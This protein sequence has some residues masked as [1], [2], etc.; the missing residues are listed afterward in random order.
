MKKLAFKVGFCLLLAIAGFATFSPNSEAQNN[1]IERLLDLPAPPPPNAIIERKPK[2]YY[3]LAEMPADDAPIEDL[4]GFWTTYGDHTDDLEYK[5]TPSEKT[6]DRIIEE[7]QQ[8]PEDLVNRLGIFPA[9]SKYSEIIRNI[10]ESETSKTKF[11]ISWRNSIKAWLTYNSK[12]YSNDLLEL[13]QN[14][15]DTGE[16]LTNHDDLVALGKIDWEKARPIVDRLMNDQ[17]QPISQTAARWVAYQHA[18]DVGNTSDADRYRKELQ[19]IVENKNEKPGNRDLAMD[20]IVKVGDFSGR[21]DWYFSLL[22]DETLLDLKVNGD[23]YTGI[24]TILLN[25]TPG[26]YTAKMIELTKSKN[27]TVRSIAAKN[28]EDSI[29]SENPEVAKALLPWLEDPNWANDVSGIRKKLIEYLESEVVIESVPG[30]LAVLNEKSKQKLGD[31]EDEDRVDAIVKHPAANTA[32]TKLNKADVG[33]NDIEYYPFRSSAISALGTQKDTRAIS[34]LRTLLP[35]VDS[36]ERP[37]VVRALL[38]CNGFSISEQV[39]A[40]ELTAKDLDKNAGFQTKTALIKGIPSANTLIQKPRIAIGNFSAQDQDSDRPYNPNQIPAILGA[41]LVEEREAS[42]ELV[43]AMISRISALER[44][45]PKIATIM[46]NFVLNWSGKAV[47]SLMLDDLKTN[48][49]DI[50]SVIELLILRKELRESQ[51]N[52]V[53][54]IRGGNGFA[55]GIS[56]CILEQ[57]SEY[58]SILDGENLEAK[59]AMLGCAK[60]VRA[61]MPI[62]KVAENLQSTNKMLAL[63]AERYLESEDSPQARQILLSL[64]PNDAKIFGATTAFF[65]TQNQTIDVDENRLFTLFTGF[66]KTD[67]VDE[68]EEGISAN[69]YFSSSPDLLTTEKRLQKE[70]KEKTELTGIYSYDD[71]FVRIYKDQAVFSWEEDE[72]R[73]RE[74]TLTKEEF[75]N[76]TSYLSFNQVDELSSFIG[77]CDYCSGKELLMISRN[78]GRRVFFKSDTSPKFFAGLEEILSDFREPPAKLHYW[79]ETIVPGLEILFEDENLLAQTV[80]KTGDE[81]NILVHNPTLRK[82]LQLELGAQNQ[83]DYQRL[84]ANQ[85]QEVNKKIAADILRRQMQSEF[86]AYS[87]HK[88]EQNQLGPVV[89]QPSDIEFHP[90]MGDVIEFRDSNWKSR[91]SKYVIS[92]DRTALYKTFNGATTKLKLGSYANAVVAG[93]GNWV[94]ARKYAQ[95]KESIVRINLLTG[96]ELIIKMPESTWNFKI[97]SFIPA[98]NKIV[99]SAASE[100]GEENEEEVSPREGGG[101]RKYYLLNAETGVFEV[102]KG[103]VAPN[104]Q[105]TYRPL[106]STGKPNEFWAAVSSNNSTEIGRFDSKLLKFNSLLKLPKI[107]F[108]SMTMLVNEKESK[109]YFVYNGQLLRMPLP[110]AV[111]K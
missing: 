90:K 76:L 95:Y 47:N 82:K 111:V 51:S 46:R 56:A 97:E 79:L 18:I 5:P 14:I 7:L 48:K 67:E 69:Y 4:L 94:V 77:I 50:N 3:S 78:G 88:F 42:N 63:A 35:E 45:L 37:D 44:K 106:Q 53:H 65:F 61:K 100:N 13:A 21:D 31:D 41:E 20:A 102:T 40:L 22:E 60:L 62:Q 104:A 80:W 54:D 58:D 66:S 59:T 30:L 103:N 105:Q 84:D 49:A 108:N 55:L 17:S 92:T 11:S 32:R 27:K 107:E 73:Y 72:S 33:K 39:N 109:L 34:P 101:R 15:K 86:D 81:L 10:Y 36:D 6:L 89:T 98:L 52:E 93:E 19:K 74:R 99:I 87:W 9:E 38:E 57:N 1:I 85:S 23:S 16:Y 70:V 83:A 8:H 2:K 64:H 96:N 68:D 110:K 29:D 24:T 71:N 12:Y 43:A 26:K 25:S 91:N 28:L 75:S